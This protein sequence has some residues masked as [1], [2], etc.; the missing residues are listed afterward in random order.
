MRNVVYLFLLF[1]CQTNC[2]A[3]KIILVG[4]V[5]DAQS[6]QV[7]PYVGVVNKAT[8]VGS[9]GKANGYYKISTET[10]S[11]LTF[12]AIGYK[13]LQL[14]IPIDEIIDTIEQNIYM[15]RD[16]ISIN[17]VQIRAFPNRAQF[18]TEFVNKKL[19]KDPIQKTQEVVLQALKQTPAVYLGS[20]GGKSGLSII[21][22]SPTDVIT[23]MI[24][25]RKENKHRGDAYKEFWSTMPDSIKENNPHKSLD[26]IENE[27]RE[28]R[29]KKGNGWKGG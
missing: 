24:R 11:T 28:E 15:Y 22:F 1:I 2:F 12:S 20:T 8:K 7:I 18:S 14:I 6:Y 10:G 25:K 21:S 19:E 29:R 16:T 4:Q 13:N 3:Q 5:L 17:E 26:E 9:I 23:R 27:L